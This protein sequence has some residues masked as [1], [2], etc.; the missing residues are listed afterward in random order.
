MA[1]MTNPARVPADSADGQRSM[2]NFVQATIAVRHTLPIWSSS[3][4]GSRRSPRTVSLT[5]YAFAR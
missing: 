3:F 1:S 4:L 5:R 2:P